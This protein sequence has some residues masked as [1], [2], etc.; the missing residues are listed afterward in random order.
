MSVGL[1]W[2]LFCGTLVVL[3]TAVHIVQRAGRTLER[4]GV[5]VDTH[6]L[7]LARHEVLWS[8]R[9][10]ESAAGSAA[11]RAAS[12]ALCDIVKMRQEADKWV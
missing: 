5:L 8:T 7:A 10:S 11:K 3:G 1:V 12:A 4:A 6:A 9:Y 2:A